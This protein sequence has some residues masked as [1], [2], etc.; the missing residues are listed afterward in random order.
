MLGIPGGIIA[1]CGV[2]TQ[3]ITYDTTVIGNGGDG[4]HNFSFPKFNI[5]TGTLLEVQFRSEVALSF[6]FKA[7]NTYDTS[8]NYRVRVGRADDINSAALTTPILF[9]YPTRTYGFFPLARPDGTPGSGPDFREEPVGYAL[10]HVIR[11]QTVNNTA[12]YL[13]L[14]NVAF[15]YNTVSFTSTPTGTSFVTLDDT[16]ADTLNFRITYVYC[17]TSILAADISLF[18]AKKEMR[19]PLI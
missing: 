8:L 16:S 17:L 9:D 5:P 18:T 6:G 12:D 10:N 13:G 2:N 1:Q 19:K 3:T 14:G 7:E 4:T 11:Q 15:E